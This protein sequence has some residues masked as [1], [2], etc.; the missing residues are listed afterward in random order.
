MKTALLRPLLPLITALISVALAWCYFESRPLAIAA[1]AVTLLVVA[2]G[3]SAFEIGR[4][5]LPRDPVN[6][7]RL[8][9][10]YRVAR[11]AVGALSG[12]AVI[13]TTVELAGDTLKGADKQMLAAVATAVTSFVTALVGD[14][15]G[16]ASDAAFSDRVKESFQAAYRRRPADGSTD[17]KVHY[18]APGSLGEQ[19]VYSASAPGLINGWGRDDRRKRA[20]AI[21]AELSSRSSDG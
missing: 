9:E 5:S 14:W 21:A 12:A 18:F 15:V 17:P 2:F 6:A 20:N 10:V 1:S 8:M 3:S 11:V 4:H 13:V 19:L 7:L 16:D